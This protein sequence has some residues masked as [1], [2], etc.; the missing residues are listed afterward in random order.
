VPGEYSKFL[1]DSGIVNRQ[2]RRLRC[3]RSIVT[4]Q[5]K[6]LSYR[7]RMLSHRNRMLT[8]QH[9]MLSHRNGIC[10]RDNK[11]L[12]CCIETLRLNN[13]VV[14]GNRSVVQLLNVNAG[15]QCRPGKMVKESINLQFGI[16]PVANS[17]LNPLLGG[18]PGG[19]GG[20]NLQQQ[21]TQ[22]PR[23]KLLPPR[24]TH[25]YPSLEGIAKADSQRS[26]LI[27]NSGSP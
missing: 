25:P 24:L 10:S 26:R 21:E 15:L 5:L 6:M 13:R 14:R 2:H 12:R 16:K 1:Y 9:K 11:A 7:N 3:C 18:V 22:L 4:P 17:T 27:R 8:P 19:R 20:S 23:A